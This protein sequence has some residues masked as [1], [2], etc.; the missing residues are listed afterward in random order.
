[1][2]IL[3]LDCSSG[4]SGDMAVGA[5]IDLGVPFDILN[6][7]LENIEM[8]QERISKK[9]ILAVKFDVF[10]KSTHQHAD[11][12]HHHIEDI[13]KVILQTNISDSAKKIAFDIFNVIAD[14]E[15]IVHGTP[16]GKSLHLHEVGALDSIADI[17]CLS[18]CLDYFKPDKIVFSHVN[19]GE[20]TVKCAHG[21]L[22]VPAPATVE[23]LKNIPVYSDGTKLEL[24]T[25][26]GA[27]FIKISAD[28]FG[29]LPLGKIVKT[30]YGA[31]SRE[32]DTRPNILRVM[33][34]ETLETESDFIYQI[35]TQIDDM[36]AETLAPVF[37][38]LFKNGALDVYVT[39]I[40][41]KKQRPGFL[42]TVLTNQEYKSRLEKIILNETTTFGVRSWEV[43]RTCFV[44]KI[45][46]FTSSLG[47]VRVKIG[48]F[49][50]IIKKIPEFDDCMLLAK[51]NN[52]P[53]YKVYNKII[54]EI[55]YM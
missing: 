35:E 28:E 11:H 55:E 38:K 41:M 5:M 47:T 33:L 19:T 36:T 34:I 46:K 52:I 30:G 39:Q 14:A 27:A 51:K 7:G 32:L 31:G 45:E 4:I 54:G 53:V 1:M 26:T 24:T 22:A 8:K 25:P 48:V 9:G 13:K 3:Y 37:K 23:L 16:K 43:N 42:I 49:E 21:I 50:D 20:G 29:G 12:S 2:K 10:D 44:R 6:I 40:L 15:R 18:L 17:I